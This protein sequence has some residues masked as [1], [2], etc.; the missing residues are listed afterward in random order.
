MAEELHL[1][2]LLPG[3][4][5]DSE[6]DLEFTQHAT[7]GGPR[8]RSEAARSVA[9]CLFLLFV[10]IVFALI[11]FWAGTW[12]A[13]R[14]PTLDST[15]AARTTR[16]SPLLKEV[17]IQ[18]QFH[19]F[20]G[21]FMDENIYRQSGSP[22][23]DVAWEELGVDYRAGVISYEDGLASGLGQSFVQRAGKYGGG[24]LVNVEGMHHLQVR[25]S[26]EC[27]VLLVCLLIFSYT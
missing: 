18:Y 5:D 10:M 15:C 22:E 21:S 25:T 14:R 12:V 6:D 24:F 27:G 20:N 13:M 16:W 17:S 11:S 19:D 26:C 4:P 23:V 8:K 1:H 3:G 7:N 9:K 2:R